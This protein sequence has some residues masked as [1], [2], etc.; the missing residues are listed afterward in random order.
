[1]FVLMRKLV[2]SLLTVLL[3][4]AII[5]SPSKALASDEIFFEVN[6]SLGPVEINEE[7]CFQNGVLLSNTDHYQIVGAVKDEPIG[8]EITHGKPHIILQDLTIDVSF[9]TGICAFAL[10]PGVS[11][12]LTLE[13]SNLLYSGANRGGVEV[14]EGAEIVINGAGSLDV[15][16]GTSLETGGAAIGGAAGSSAG[17]IT[18]LSGIINAEG[19]NFAAAIG[20]GDGIY[21]MELDP[22]NEAVT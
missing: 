11:A 3:I 2:S 9:E 5:C 15:R 21:G 20:G 16:G 12:E 10:L 19:G 14:P 4:I 17:I 7:G 1:M 22:S 13:G 6:I 8:I 18:I